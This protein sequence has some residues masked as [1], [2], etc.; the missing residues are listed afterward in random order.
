[1]LT[2]PIIATYLIETPLAV[3]QAAEMIAGEQSS[4][5]FLPI[6]GET[7]ELKARA[8]ARVIE[9]K[10]LEVVDQPQNS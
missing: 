3:E 2:Q 5:T 8:R 6:P 4:G 7:I 1:M 9:I 10:L